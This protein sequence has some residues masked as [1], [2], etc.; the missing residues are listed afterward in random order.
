MLTKEKLKLYWK[1]FTESPRAKKFQSVFRKVL[2][3]AIVSIII[4]QLWDIGWT[5]VLNSLPT[6]PLFYILFFVLY[7]TLPTGEVFIYRQVWAVKRW[8]S[9]KAFLTKRVYNE[10]VMGYSGE[11]YLFMW[12]RKRVG[13][14]EKEV[15]KNVRDNNILSAVSSNIVAVILIGL[16]IFTGIIEVGDIFG[17]V[18]LVYVFTGIVITIAFV[19]LFIQ[20]RKYIFALPL[21]KALIVFAIYLSRFIIHHGLLIVQWAV[22]IPDTPLSIWFL[23]IA[24]I[25]VVN[26]I[27][28]IPSRDLVFMWAGIELSRALDMATASVAGM[29]LVS[30]AMK[31]SLNLILFLIFSHFNKSEDIEELRRG[32]EKSSH[33]KKKD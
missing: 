9:F 1:Q 30:S 20:F 14:S 24:I 7:L 12:A 6:H 25:I 21:R 8:E 13:K 2:I 3:V 29:L 26:R 23:F 19:A 27:P 33:V 18:S 15:L 10:E 31:K 4:Y 32:Y 16:L 5:E 17:N 22:V 11:F 28:F